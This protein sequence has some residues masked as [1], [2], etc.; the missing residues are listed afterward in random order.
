[1]GMPSIYDAQITTA[2]FAEITVFAK[3]FVV[4]QNHSFYN[5]TP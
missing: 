5:G 3:Q 1:M 2:A 4:V